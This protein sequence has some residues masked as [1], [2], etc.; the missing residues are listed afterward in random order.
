VAT[1][2][3]P[4]YARARQNARSGYAGIAAMQDYA[5]MQ[6][7]QRGSRELFN[8]GQKYEALTPRTIAGY[9]QRGLAGP[10]ITSGVFSRGLQN[11]AS[12]EA[13]DRYTSQLRLADQLQNIQ[14][15]ED[16]AYRKMQDRLEDIDRKKANDQARIAASLRR[17]KPLMGG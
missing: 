6:A 10:G 14:S 4:S 15:K 1:L 9:T 12:A 16:V 2:G 5:R 8:I 7:Q 17:M 13:S 11:L 3:L